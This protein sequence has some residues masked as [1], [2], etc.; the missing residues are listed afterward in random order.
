MIVAKGERLLKVSVKGSNDGSWGLCQSYMKP[1]QAGR[2]A[3]LFRAGRA[4]PPQS[5]DQFHAIAPSFA[6][7]LSRFPE[8]PSF[9]GGSPLTIFI[10]SMLTRTIRPIRSTM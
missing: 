9:R 7:S 8:C 4:T 5:D 1:K 6:R 2:V 3:I 10:V